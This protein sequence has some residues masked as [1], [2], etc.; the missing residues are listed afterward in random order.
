MSLSRRCLQP[1]ARFA[2][3]LAYATPVN[4]HAG[5]VVLCGGV[6]TLARGGRIPL[7]GGRII[8]GYAFTLLVHHAKQIHGLDIL[9]RRKR[10][11]ET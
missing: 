6:I 4:V 10:A 5:Q 8:P 7:Y 2:V 3:V 9:F 1:F 11:R